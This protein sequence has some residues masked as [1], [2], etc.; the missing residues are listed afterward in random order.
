M[1]HLVAEAAAD[2]GGDHAD[3]VLGQ[4]GDERV[5]GC[6]GRAGPGWSSHRV[7]LPSTASKSAIAP[8]VSIGAGC[9]RG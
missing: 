7:S 9:T 5:T 8:Q 4:P 2:V 3:L 6:G 1:R